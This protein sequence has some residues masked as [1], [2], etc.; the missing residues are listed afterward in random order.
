MEDRD[1]ESAGETIERLLGELGSLPD[2]RA[3]DWAEKLVQV[4]TDLYGEG[5]RRVIDAAGPGV[6][7]RLTGD[8]LVGGLLVLHGLHPESLQRRAEQAVAGIDGVESVSAD[9]ETA[10]VVVALAETGSALEKRVRAAVE[11]SVPDAL[12]VAVDGPAAGSP[13]RFVN[14]KKP[15]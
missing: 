8:E 14:R 3:R 4:V 15:A 12:H 10:T 2:R 7:E 9:D 11:A 5:L 1:L 6:L 13:V